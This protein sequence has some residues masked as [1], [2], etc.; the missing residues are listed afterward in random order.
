[1]LFKVIYNIYPRKENTEIDR[2]RETKKLDFQLDED[3][4]RSLR[5]PMAVYLVQAEKVLRQKA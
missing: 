5:R 2:D 4:Q 1:M 3:E